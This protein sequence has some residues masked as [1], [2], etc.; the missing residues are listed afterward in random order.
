MVRALA[1]SWAARVAA[2]G[3]VAG[4]LL[5]VPANVGPMPALAVDRTPANPGTT[6]AVPEPEVVWRG[7]R[8]GRLVALTFD[9]GWNPKTLRGIYRTLVREDVPA[10]FFV[11]GMYV[12]RDPGLWRTIAARFPLANHSHRHRDTR[13]LS[14]RQVLA[15]LAR[16]RQAVEEATGRPMLPYFRPP[17]GYRD[18]RIDRLAAEAGFPTIVMWSVSATDVERGVT[19]GSVIRSASGGRSGSIVLLHAGPSVTVRALPGIIARYRARGFRFVTVPEL[20]GHPPGGPVVDRAAGGSGATVSDLDYDGSGGA[21]PADPGDPLAG[22]PPD[23]SPGPA[24]PDVTGSAP[25]ARDSA[26]ARSTSAPGALAAGSVVA[27]LA[28]TA[29]GAIVGRRTRRKGEAGG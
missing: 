23:A 24:V 19:K 18:R 5:T 17:Y 8:T 15:D 25:L 10:T 20:L 7:P 6:D 2:A 12:Q 28:M 29:A 27:L 4:L 22:A 13:E 9:D 26:W 1:R 14:D 21:S 16:A 11:T 3:L